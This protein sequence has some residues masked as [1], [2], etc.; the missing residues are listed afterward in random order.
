MLGV[1]G[2]LEWR[3]Y[4]FSKKRQGLEGRKYF[5]PKNGKERG[6][7]LGISEVLLLSC[8]IG[9]AKIFLLKKRQRGVVA[10]YVGTTKH[11]TCP[12]SSYIR[13]VLLTAA[14]RPTFDVISRTFLMSDSVGNVKCIMSADN[15]ELSN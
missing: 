5:F 9:E 10:I 7:G 14:P 3:N 4:F 1:W 13:N 6:E 8:Q 12:A 15:E 11:L 2:W